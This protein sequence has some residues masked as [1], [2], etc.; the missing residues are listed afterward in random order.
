MNKNALRKI[1]YGM[2]I[3]TSKN[4]DKINGQIANAVLQMTSDPIT[5]G[6]CVNHNN[7]TH[8]FIDKSKV[9]T[10]SILS[11][12]TPMKLI[13]NFGYK[14]GHD[15]DKFVGINYKIGKNGVPIVLDST[16]AFLELELI[17]HVGMDSHTM[18]VGKVV[19]GDILSDENPMTYAYYHTVKGGKS[20]KSAPHYVEAE[21]GKNI[22]PGGGSKMDKYVCIVCDYVYKP[23]KGDPDEGIEPGTKFEDLPDD[24]VCPICG[25]SKDEFEKEE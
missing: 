23:A 7:L 8:E 16:V 21:E 20:P 17:N 13:G 5:I 15:I 22:K 14:S 10:I 11:D 18:Y 2:Y 6:V 9:F 25:A 3:L 4:G 12:D 24:W 19:N 1:S